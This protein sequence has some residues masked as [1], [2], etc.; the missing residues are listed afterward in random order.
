MEKIS[1][2]LPSNSRVT[3]VDME[4]SQP[5]RRGV[6]AFG[7]R[8]VDANPQDKISLSGIDHSSISERLNTYKPRDVQ[9][10]EIATRVADDFF[11]NQKPDPIVLESDLLLALD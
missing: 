1:G 4:R 3:S 9:N 7:R 2:I 5:V 8:V 6:P 11:M 10:R